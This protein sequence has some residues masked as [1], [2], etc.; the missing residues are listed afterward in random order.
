MGSAAMNRRRVLN[1]FSGLL[2]GTLWAGVAAAAGPAAADSG[3]TGALDLAAHRGKV[4]YVDFW[5]S[6]CVPCK[7]SFPWMNTMHRQYG[8]DG[9]VIIAVNMDQVRAE[10]NAFLSKYPAEFKVHYD[11]E[12]KLAPQFKVRGMPTSALL[13]RDGKVLLIHEGFKSKD[14]ATLE[15]AIRDALR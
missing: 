13:G 8:K 9:L 12:G 11:P 3:N 10:A 2:L 7:Q 1:G 14:A 5:A 6:W 4:V 15:Q